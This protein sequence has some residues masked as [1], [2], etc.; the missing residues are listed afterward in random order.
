MKKRVYFILLFLFITFPVKVMGFCTTDEKI[1]Y[2]LL[3]SNI[4]TSYDYIEV[5]DSVSFNLTIHNVHR[6]LIIIDKQTG[7]KY[8]SIYNDLNNFV[9]KNLK[10]GSCY[11]FEVYADNRDC[12]YTL[13]N[14]LYVNLPKYNKYYKDQI[15]EGASE[16]LYCQKWAEIGNL[17]YDEFVRLVNDYKSKG[18]SE[19]VKP[20]EEEK[21]EWIYIVMD[22]WS[23]Y[24]LFVSV[25][26]ILVC[27][28]I[29]IIKNKRDDFDF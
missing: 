4:T 21:K 23:K 11:L 14:T 2:S 17:S 1:R 16:Y 27:L 25:G 15:C 28:A 8:K 18:T 5:G 10:D 29:I 24:Y 26:I 19:I 20:T 3:S 7:L 12:S 22:L 13:Y 9:I 6:D